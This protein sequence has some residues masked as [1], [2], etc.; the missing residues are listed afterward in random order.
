LYGR[1]WRD[2]GGSPG[3]IVESIEQGQAT[4]SMEWGQNMTVCVIHDEH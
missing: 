1:L 4:M 2:R 3:A